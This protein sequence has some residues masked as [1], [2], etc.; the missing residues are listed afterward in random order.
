MIWQV[1]K[2]WEGG[3]VWIIG[4]GPSIT[5]Q[6]EIP[7]HVVKTVINGSSSPSVYSDYMKVIHNKHTIGVNVAY[8]IGD[9]MDIVFFGD[10]TF[11]LERKKQLAEYPGI[12]VSCHPNVNCYDYVKYVP[13]DTNY[14]HGITSNSRMVSWNNNSGA[15][16]INLAV[17]TG[18]KRIILLGFD[19]TL[20][21]A[22]NQ[23]WHD[24][25][26]RRSRILDPRNKKRMN[27]FSTFDTHLIGFEAISKDAKRLG[28]EIINCSPDSKITHFRKCNVKDLL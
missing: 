6:F 28:V 5:K 20:D 4:G 24:L 26:G 19:M 18:A 1:P 21:S 2:I 7:D 23:H 22:S 25:Y 9:W 8:L 12:K 14:P 11:F 15:A 17:R 13:K 3:D 16:A 10:V 27:V